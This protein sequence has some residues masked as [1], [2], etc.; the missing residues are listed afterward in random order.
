[1]SVSLA[2]AHTHALLSY[3]RKKTYISTIDVL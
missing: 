2:V 1:M 3:D